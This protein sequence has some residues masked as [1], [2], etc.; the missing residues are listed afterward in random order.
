M[1]I[2]D[3]INIKRIR[4]ALVYALI[5][6]VTVLLQI[7]VF[8]RIAL[9][10]VKPMFIPVT[11]VAIGMFKDGFWGGV[12]GAAAGLLSDMASSDTTVLYTLVF[13]A[14]GFLAG[15]AGQ[16]LINRRLYSYLVSS[17]AALAVTAFCQCLRLWLYRG[18]PPLSMLSTAALQVL[19]SLP[20]GIPAYFAVRTATR[21]S[22]R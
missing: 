16:E 18:T 12:A 17:A 2:F 7:Y 14:L 22:E 5:L 1:I 3:L 9:L 6:G 13:T 20:F 19:W 10:G 8:S 15:L 11:L 4:L 21:R